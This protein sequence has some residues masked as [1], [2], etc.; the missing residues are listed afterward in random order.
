M[1]EFLKVFGGYKISTIITFIL[2]CV[3]L[4]KMIVTMRNYIVEEYEEKKKKDEMLQ[5]TFDIVNKYQELRKQDREQ[6]LQIQKQ[7]KESIDEIKRIQEENNNKLQE[8]DKENKKRE[9][10]RLRNSLLYAYQEYADED[11]NPMM[12]W[13]EMER[14]TFWDLFSDYENLGGDGHMHTEVQPV[15][16]RLEIIPMTE[17]EK[18]IKLMQSRKG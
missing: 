6:S 14:Q 8:M 1:E 2:A 13:T 11:R 10:N 7:L 9:V 16:N 17:K 4:S 3:F 18:I 5:Q 15:M 12:A